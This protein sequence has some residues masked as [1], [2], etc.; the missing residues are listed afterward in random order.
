MIN[1]KLILSFF[2]IYNLYK[3]KGNILKYKDDFKNNNSKIKLLLIPHAGK[4]FAGKS[5]ENCFKK[6]TRNINQIFYIAAVHNTYN[7]K[8][9]F[10]NKIYIQNDNLN[11]FNDD[12]F[13]KNLN[14]EQN[15]LISNE[16]S[17]RWVKDEI[18][19]YF[20]NPNITVIYPQN[21]FSNNL[22][23]E[24]LK[25]ELNKNNVLVIGTSDFI[26][27][28][29]NYKITGWNNPQ[30][31]KV[32]LEGEFIKNICKVNISNVNSFYNKYKDYSMK[33]K[34]G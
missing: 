1:Y 9:A 23:S 34:N 7:F 15:K 2:I 14:Y 19:K 26:H 22:I 21:N 8:N 33:N 30:E 31:Q 32:Y 11:I 17:Y 27:Y 24:I 16:H 3:N 5:R 20:N 4:K 12:I 10:N 13:I 25:K 6:I 18:I 29:D 28:G